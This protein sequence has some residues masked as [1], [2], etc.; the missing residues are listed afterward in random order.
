MH[1]WFTK[2]FVRLRSYVIYMFRY[3]FECPYLDFIL[4][5]I[6]RHV[7]IYKI[8]CKCFTCPI[9]FLDN[10]EAILEELENEVKKD[11]ANIFMYFVSIYSFIKISPVFHTP[12]KHMIS[13]TIL[14]LIFFMNVTIFHSNYKL[15]A[16][17]Q[18]VYYSGKSFI[19]GFLSF[20]IIWIFI[21]YSESINGLTLWTKLCCSFCKN[22]MEL[23]SCINQHYWRFYWIQRL[24]SNGFTMMSL[25]HLSKLLC[26]W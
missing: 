8:L 1:H 20:K 14:W 17:R 7:K 24:L 4:W 15:V 26:I 9:L 5:K 21:S 6:H 18:S 22:S 12:M 19:S 11:I 25:Q 2:M 10:H 16:Q 13:K 3:W 23:K